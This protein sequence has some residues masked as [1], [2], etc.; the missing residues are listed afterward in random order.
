MAYIQYIYI[1]YVYDDNQSRETASSSLS[2]H[3]QRDKSSSGGMYSGLWGSSTLQFHL[4][5][6]ER[7]N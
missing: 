2:L 4:L 5:H 6:T 7:Q 1:K 3:Q